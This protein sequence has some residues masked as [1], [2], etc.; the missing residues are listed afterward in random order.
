MIER[1]KAGIVYSGEDVVSPIGR[2]VSKLH[3]DY[4]DALWDAHFW[5]KAALGELWEE[6]QKHHQ[7]DIEYKM[8]WG[9]DD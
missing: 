2:L 3:E 8:E 7:E 9:N 1:T 6:A 4:I 5:R